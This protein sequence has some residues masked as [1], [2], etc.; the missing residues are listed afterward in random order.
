MLS[1]LHAIWQADGTFP[2]G[3]FSFSY[4]VEGIV[5]LRSRLDGAALAELTKAVIRQ[6]WMGF[7]RIALLRAFR[8]AGYWRRRAVARSLRLPCRV[9][10]SCSMARSS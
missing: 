2:S 1:I 3:S 7:D 8:A 10:R 9:T 4:G 5:A 6:R